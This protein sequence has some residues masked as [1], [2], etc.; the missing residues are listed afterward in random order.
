MIELWK[1][2]KLSAEKWRMDAGCLSS[3]DFKFETKTFFNL[4]FD[5]FAC[6]AFKMVIWSISMKEFKKKK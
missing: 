4:K 2:K 3:F 1:L 6:F 5:A